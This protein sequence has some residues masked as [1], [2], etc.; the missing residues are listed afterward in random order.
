MSAYIYYTATPGTASA[1]MDG[2]TVRWGAQNAGKT[3]FTLAAV[4]Q[5]RNMADT[6]AAHVLPD[7]AIVGLRQALSATWK[8]VL[9]RDV[10]LSAFAMSHYQWLCN[11]QDRQG[12][13]ASSPRIT[14][15]ATRGHS[16]PVAAPVY[17][18]RFRR[19][20]RTIATNPAR[21]PS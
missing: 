18:R 12:W 14:P 17:Q 2:Y 15:P 20:D 6:Y 10:T 11:I 7:P 13:V 9:H 4:S 3:G 19:R 1:S 16:R 5:E 21:N 8:L